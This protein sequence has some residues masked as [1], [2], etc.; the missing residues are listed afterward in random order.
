MSRNEL[1]FFHTPSL[2]RA[3][4]GAQPVPGAAVNQPWRVRSTAAMGQMV[5][6]VRAGV[7]ATVLGTLQIFKP[8]LGICA[9]GQYIHACEQ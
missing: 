5:I 6:A 4:P 7:G 3:K 2:D 9:N 1:L 8:H